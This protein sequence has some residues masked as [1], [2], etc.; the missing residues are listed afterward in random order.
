MVQ[1]DRIYHLSNLAVKPAHQLVSG[2]FPIIN[3]MLTW[4]QLIGKGSARRRKRKA[5]ISDC[6]AVGGDGSYERC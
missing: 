1:L 6:E 5:W 3:P 4:V 2:S